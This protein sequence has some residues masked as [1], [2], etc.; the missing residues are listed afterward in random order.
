MDVPARPESSSPVAVEYIIVIY[1]SFIIYYYCFGNYAPKVI[2]ICAIFSTIMNPIP[3]DKLQCAHILT[4]A[5]A[6][7]QPHICTHAPQHT[8]THA[9]TDQQV[10]KQSSFCLL[11][12]GGSSCPSRIFVFFFAFRGRLRMLCSI[13][14]FFRLHPIVLL[15][16][17]GGQACLQLN[18]GEDNL[19]LTPTSRRALAVNGF[20]FLFAPAGK[21]SRV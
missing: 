11:S 4:Q 20:W 13:V 21:N 2:I 12:T 18:E 7:M 9:Q 14:C 17:I 6:C 16:A 19:A 10:Q 8:R 5:H 15:G 1:Y 3:T